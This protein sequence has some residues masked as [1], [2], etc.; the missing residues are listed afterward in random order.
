MGVA[1]NDWYH[2]MGSTYG[3]WVRGDPRGWR[4]RYHRKHVEGDYRNPPKAGTW[5]A[6]Y[7]L[8]IEQMKRDAVRL[9]KRLRWIAIVAIVASLSGDG[10]EVL[11]ASLDDHHLHV[12]GRFRKHNPRRLLGWAKFNATKTVKRYL[13]AHGAAV[14]PTLELRDGE[15]IWAK[16]SKAHPINDRGHQVNSCGYIADHGKRGAVVFI[17]PSVEVALRKKG[18]LPKMK[19]PRRRRGLS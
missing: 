5:E 2:C 14:G 11:V 15:G 12:L 3:T 1:W 17:H 6:A 9:E 7:Q 18:K 10:V 8:S 4:E 16:R 13:K 19:N